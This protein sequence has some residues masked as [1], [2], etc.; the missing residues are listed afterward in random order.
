MHAWAN[1]FGPKD[2][3]PETIPSVRNLISDVM[4]DIP[5][6]LSHHKSEMVEAVTKEANRVYRLWCKNNPGFEKTGRVHLIAYSLGSIMALD[7]LSKQPTQLPKNID[8]TS[9]TINTYQFDIDTESLFFCDSPAGF[10]LLL[11]KGMFLFISIAC[12]TQP[13]LTE[14]LASLLPRKGRNK[15]G[16]DGEDAGRRVAGEVHTYGCLAIDNIYNVLNH[17]DRMFVHDSLF[18]HKNSSTN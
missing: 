9:S 5:Y 1:E 16:A 12:Y 2:I 15:P 14:N 11:N 8:L 6:Y 4:R 7:I 17:Y 10:F 3:T 13:D 18:S